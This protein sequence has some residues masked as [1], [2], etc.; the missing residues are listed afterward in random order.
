MSFICDKMFCVIQITGVTP[1]PNLTADS[2][3]RLVFRSAEW[4]L[5]AESPDDM[6]LGWRRKSIYIF[7]YSLKRSVLCYI[8]S[9]V[10]D[11]VER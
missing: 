3:L 1:P 10:V 7:L 2:L 4:T 11:V 8:N 5:C 6:R 9:I